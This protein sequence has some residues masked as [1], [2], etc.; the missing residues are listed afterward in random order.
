MYATISSSNIR[1]GKSSPRSK[2][3]TLIVDQS[4]G[5][6]CSLNSECDYGLACIRNLCVD[7]CNREEYDACGVNA[8]CK[9]ST[10]N[11]QDVCI[12]ILL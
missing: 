7:P 6:E 8:E 3:K 1:Y 5:T 9:V 4:K 10:V 11:D 2:Y 12:E